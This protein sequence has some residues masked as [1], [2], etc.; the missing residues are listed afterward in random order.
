MTELDLEES[1]SESEVSNSTNSNLFEKSSY[2]SPTETMHQRYLDRLTETIPAMDLLDHED[3][4]Q[5]SPENA[6]SSYLTMLDEDKA[7]GNYLK[8]SQIKP[9]QRKRMLLLIDDLHT[10]K[11]YKPETLYL[12]ANLADRYL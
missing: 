7:L 12:A 6:Q 10:L 4:R 2:F 11:G 1:E 8:N 5:F 3:D 9:G